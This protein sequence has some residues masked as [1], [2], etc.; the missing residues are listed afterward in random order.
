MALGGIVWLLGIASDPV[1]R[2]MAARFFH[3]AVVLQRRY[4]PG[5]PYTFLTAYFH[6][7]MLAA[8]RT[9]DDAAP[10]ERQVA[11]VRRAARSRLLVPGT[12]IVLVLALLEIGLGLALILA[13][14]WPAF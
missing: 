7:T 1:R 5:E 6:D 8:L 14:G 3:R 2:E 11:A 10:V 9:V 4:A 12:A 13:V